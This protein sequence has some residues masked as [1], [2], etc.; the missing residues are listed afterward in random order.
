MGV[1]PYVNSKTTYSLSAAGLLCICCRIT[2][3]AGSLMISC[4]SGSWIAAF[5][6]A[7]GSSWLSQRWR[8]VWP[9]CTIEQS[10]E[11]N[12]E[13][14][15]HSKRQCI[16][17]N[18]STQFIYSRGLISVCRISRYVCVWCRCSWSQH[19]YCNSVCL[20]PFAIGWGDKLAATP[21][22]TLH[23]AAIPHVAHARTCLYCLVC[24]ILACRP[25][26]V[27]H[28]TVGIQFQCFFK[29][30]SRSYCV[31]HPKKG[32]T[33]ADICFYYREKVVCAC[34]RIMCV[35]E[36]TLNCCLIYF[37]HWAYHFTHALLYTVQTRSQK[38]PP[39]YYFTHYTYQ[40]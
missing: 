25:L 18:A 19:N 32:M 24:I 1:F 40:M 37:V 39:H 20:Q 28:H 26:Y 8:P 23:S 38:I 11:V 30:L 33:F 22:L 5:L 34:V 21:T 31:L 9:S 4:T 7:S 3:I 16:G 15:I 10:L 2:C 13:L 17:T 6:L 12:A 36:C 27:T 29:C 35:R 14:H